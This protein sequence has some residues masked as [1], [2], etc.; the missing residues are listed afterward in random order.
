[1]ENVAMISVGIIAH[2]WAVYNILSLI[3]LYNTFEVKYLGR[4]V[5]IHPPYFIPFALMIV[6]WVWVFVG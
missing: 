5:I 3:Q 6:F 1:M 4:N 2:L